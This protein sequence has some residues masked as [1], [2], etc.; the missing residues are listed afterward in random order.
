MPGIY[1]EM[2]DRGIMLLILTKAFDST[3]KFAKVHW[4][5]GAIILTLMFY[6]THV[7]HVNSDW[8]MVVV[9][10][11][12]LPGVYGLLLMYIRLGTGSLALPIALHGYINAIGYLV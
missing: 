2:F 3:W 6:L 11:D 12:F 9:W 5:W 8:N 10:G 4:N 7:V 1:E